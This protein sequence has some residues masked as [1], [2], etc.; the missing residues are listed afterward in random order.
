MNDLERRIIAPSLLSADF[1]KMGDAVRLLENAGADWVHVDVMDGVFVPTLTFGPKMV[2]DLRPLTKLPLDVHLMVVNPERYV[3]P[4]IDAG[5][6]H[7]TFHLEAETHAHR[8]LQ[9]ISG[10]GKKAGICI[11]PSS[12]ALLLTEILDMLDIILVMTVNPGFG[13]QKLIPQCVEKIRY[14]YAVKREKGYRFRIAADG[15]IDR[16]TVLRLASAGVDVFIT[17]SA[18]FS[19]KDPAAE[20]MFLRGNNFV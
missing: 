18:F 9:T 3:K 20:V 6:D 17:G 10:L 16:T 11:V 19:A 8:L 1:S 5:A 12:P 13:G 15:G 2:A 7:I 4:M 14:L